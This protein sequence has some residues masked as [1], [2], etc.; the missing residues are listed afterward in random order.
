MAAAGVAEGRWAQR[1]WVQRD[2]LSAP[3]AVAT[4]AA[5]RGQAQPLK[6]R[7]E[8]NAGA[9]RAAAARAHGSELGGAVPQRAA[10]ARLRP[11]RSNG[12]GRARR[13]GGR[14]ARGAFRVLS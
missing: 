11:A 2:A 3:R 10:T 13:D 7:P 5:P 14:A 6:W 1:G 9:A 8:G 12:C 4:A